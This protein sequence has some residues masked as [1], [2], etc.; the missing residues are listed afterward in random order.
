MN[1]YDHDD[2]FKTF[3]IDEANALLSEIIDVTEAAIVE[4]EKLKKDHTAGQDTYPE[5]ELKVESA[6]IL[7]EWA[8]KVVQLGAY[9]KGYFTVDFKTTVPDTLLCWTYGESSIGFTH[10]VFESFKDRQPI[11]DLGHLGFEQSM[12]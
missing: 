7:E 3:T 10:K 4:L 6:L 11:E 9:P 8:A 5:E 2:G 1:L 12:N